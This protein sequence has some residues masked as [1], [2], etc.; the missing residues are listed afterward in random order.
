MAVSLMHA[1]RQKRW[2][3][4]FPGC[5]NPI[6]LF[7]WELMTR[8]RLNAPNHALQRPAI[9]SRLQ[10]CALVGRVAELG[11]LAEVAIVKNDD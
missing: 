4:L 9:A 1:F 3:A 2:R 8:P 5:D 10:S 7:V 6:H 11:S